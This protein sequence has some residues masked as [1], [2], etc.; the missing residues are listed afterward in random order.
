MI[1]GY[2]ADLKER[3][4]VHSKEEVVRRAVQLGLG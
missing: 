1:Y 4:A 2:T 3:F